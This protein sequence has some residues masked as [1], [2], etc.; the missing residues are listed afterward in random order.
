MRARGKL[1]LVLSIG[2]VVGCDDASTTG[3]TT[4]SGSTGASPTTGSN[5]SSMSSSMGSSMGTGGSGGVPNPLTNPED[6]PPAGNP[7][8]H[9][10]VPNE[11]G[12]ADVSSPKTVVG[13]GTAASCTG[14]KVIDA[15]AKGGVITFAC[16]GTAAAPFVLK[17]TKE[18][19][20]LGADVVLDGGGIVTLSGNKVTRILHIGKDDNFEKPTPRVVVQKLN[21]VDGKTTDAPA[22]KDTKMGG[23]A[24]YRLGGTLAVIDSK[25]VNNIGPGDGQD[26]AGG[27]IY[28]VGGST[29]TIVGS[30]F[31]GNKCSNGGAVGNLG[32][33]GLTVVNSSFS[34][35]A[36]T[37]QNANP[38]N[39]GNG[40]AI[41][42]DGPSQSGGKDIAIDICG[43]TF[44]RNSAGVKA[45]GGAIFRT[46]DTTAL[47]KKTAPVTIDRS[48]FDANESG[49]AG[50]L[51][52][53]Q[54]DLTVTS[55]TFSNNVS[56]AGAGGAIW[57]EGSDEGPADVTLKLTNVTVA[58]NTAREALGGG[59]FIGAHVTGGEF[60]HVTVASNEVTTASGNQYLVFGAGIV[61]DVTKLKLTNSIFANN[62]K[63]APVAGES[64]NCQ[65]GGFIDGGGNVEFISKDHPDPK[66]CV[67][68][69]TVEDPLLAAL[70]LTEGPTQT[71]SLGTGSPAIGKGTAN[72]TATDQRGHARKTPCAAGAF[73]P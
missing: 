35:N 45:F 18:L 33:A 25:F 61:G 58:K 73:E 21:F 38:G 42:F 60:L 11:A 22:T 49:S 17:L 44:S 37:G 72:C 24:I 69:S 30:S 71:M 62:K 52:M 20:V 47:A 67:S 51:Y 34:D 8:G 12:L 65:P 16:G 68:G 39:G 59:F 23:A 3:G 19:K 6:G 27:A 40:G 36:A 63:P 64:A 4:N 9:C 46:C 10:S 41:C 50:A 29:T 2:V 31:S 66:R 26:V 70:S 5:G 15:V 55:S 43:V 48:T 13:D 54:V 53:H 14:Q 56:R 28:S 57:A 7:D 1:L 32:M